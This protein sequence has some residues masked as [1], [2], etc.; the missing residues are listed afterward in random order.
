[1]LSLATFPSKGIIYSSTA[2]LFHA[3]SIRQ[4]LC[5]YPPK[6]DLAWPDKKVLDVG[7]FASFVHRWAEEYPELEDL[8]Y[9][10]PQSSL[11]HK[12]IEGEAI[13]LFK[14]HGIHHGVQCK[15]ALDYKSMM[16]EY[17][18][19]T[20]YAPLAAQFTGDETDVF[21]YQSVTSTLNRMKTNLEDRGLSL[22]DR[23]KRI[24]MIFVPAGITSVDAKIMD[25]FNGK[26]AAA[27]GPS[28]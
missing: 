15:S 3:A 10:I 25:A 21:G 1:M 24:Q 17:Y 26:P 27:P 4:F 12:P 7:E 16:K 23:G 20:P 6:G 8:A 22:V 5:D 11:S 13:Y 9:E 28:S 2:V 18:L 19:L 14:A